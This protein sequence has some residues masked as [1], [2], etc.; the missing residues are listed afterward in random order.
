MLLGPAQRCEAQQVAK[1]TN[2]HVYQ[3]SARATIIE[4][5][6]TLTLIL[7][8]LPKESGRVVR[9]TLVYLLGR[10]STA[11]EIHPHLRPM[12]K[13]GIRLWRL[14]SLAKRQEEIEKELGAS[15]HN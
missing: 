3:F 7:A 1:G 8:Q 5:S 9:D 2:S 13:A 11:T 14:L 12:G 6:D 15:L 4:K 10:D